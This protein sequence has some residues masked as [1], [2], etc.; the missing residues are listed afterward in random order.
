M[1]QKRQNHTT[2][3]R[4]CLMTNLRSHDTYTDVISFSC[5]TTRSTL[6][7]PPFFLFFWKARF[8]LRANAPTNARACLLA[9][10]CACEH[11]FPRVRALFFSLC[12]FFFCPRGKACVRASVQTQREGAK[13][14]AH[15]MLWW[16]V[17]G[18]GVPREPVAQVPPPS[19]AK[20]DS[21]T[22]SETWHI[23]LL[24]INEC[25]HHTLHSVKR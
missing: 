17:S 18:V 22:W 3:G 1:V 10:T 7:A 14:S 9:G 16:P 8:L 2:R 21:S 11:A 23:S 24:W 6:G 4:N 13:S 19:P 15:A 25:K 12:S 20:N 5:A